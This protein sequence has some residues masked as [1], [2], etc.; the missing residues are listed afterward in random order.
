MPYLSLAPSELLALSITCR[1]RDIHVLRMSTKMM[2][3]AGGGASYL[4]DGLG[5][6]E[7]LENRVHVAGG[8]GILETHV[9]TWCPPHNK[10]LELHVQDY[11]SM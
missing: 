3:V 5:H 1:E 11:I 9:P 2:F 10:R 6:V 4:S 7:L 8:S